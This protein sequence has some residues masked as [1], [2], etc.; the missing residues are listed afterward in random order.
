MLH[1]RNYLSFSK[2]TLTTYLGLSSSTDTCLERPLDIS[3]KTWDR[4][5]IKPL[6][7][8]LNSIPSNADISSHY[9]LL[10]ILLNAPK[11]FLTSHLAIA[12]SLL[13]PFLPGQV[14]L[15]ESLKGEFAKS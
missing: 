7:F 12:S 11:L 3:P 6:F 8:L 4:R 13:K 9:F 1:A 2:L 15:V 5:L 14:H 10:L